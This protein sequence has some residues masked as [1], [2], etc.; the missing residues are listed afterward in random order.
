MEDCGRDKA[1]DKIAIVTFHRTGN[2]GAALQSYALQTVLNERFNVE[3]L[4]YRNKYLEKLYS[5]KDYSVKDKA[6]LLARRLVYPVKTAQLDKR[7]KRFEEFYQR[8]HHLSDTVYNL[9]NIDEA[10]AAYDAFIAGS[11]QVWNP[12]LSRDDWNYFLEFAP[13]RKRFSYAASISIDNNNETNERMRRDLSEFNS[14]LVREY[15]ALPFLES[16][17]VKN[18]AV[19]VCDPV[20]LM[21]PDEWRKSLSLG[22]GNA[23][24]KHV[25]LYTVANVKESLD[26]AKELA[27][28]NNLPVVSIGSNQSV[29]TVDGVTNILDAG[30]MEFLRYIQ[31]AAFVVT[32]SFHAMAF[33]IIF[34]VPFFYELCQDGSNNND[35]LENVAEVLHLKNRNIS[36]IRN[37]N[38][39]D[40]IDWEAVN[41]LLK[42]YRDD[43][44]KSLFD[45]LNIIRGECGE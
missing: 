2:Y 8:F 40:E 38:Y 37:N 29:K 16:I 34:N 21:T 20:F 42:Q 22:E 39:F 36:C 27:K 17:G 31:E 14:I 6:R 30:P 33:S 28:N 43:S 35:R 25:L 13:A 26:F 11:D 19:A 1:R 18:Q 7:K 23:K 41:R 12:H 15:K 10:P 45:S 3:I 5:Q 44:L 4:D 9:D 32:S 24:G